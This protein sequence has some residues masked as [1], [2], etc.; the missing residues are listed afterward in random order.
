M[1]LFTSPPRTF[2]SH[3]I[4]NIELAGS[5]RALLKPHPAGWEIQMWNPGHCMDSTSAHL[6][7]PALVRMAGEVLEYPPGTIDPAC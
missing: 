5:L 2:G 1:Q 6:H 4:N 7:L 3:M